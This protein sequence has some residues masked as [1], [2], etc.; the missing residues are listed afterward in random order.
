MLYRAALPRATS[1]FLNKLKMKQ[2]IA[3][4][5]ILAKKILLT[6]NVHFLFSFEFRQLLK[7]KIPPIFVLKE[8]VQGELLLMK[9]QIP[10]CSI[11]NLIR[12]ISSLEMSNIESKII[13]RELR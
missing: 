6:R 11:G 9:C 3:S 8:K 2:K 12:F 7:K 13:M 10:F 1:T 5:K 4:K